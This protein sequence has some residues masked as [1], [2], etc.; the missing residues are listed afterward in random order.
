MEGIIKFLI[1]EDDQRILE[2]VSIAFNIRWPEANVVSTDLGEKGLEMVEAERPDIVILDL[3][4]PDISGFEVLKQIRLFSTVPIIVMSVMG[5]EEDVVRGLELGADEYVIKPFRQLEFLSRVK[6][7]LRI[8]TLPGEEQPLVYGPLRFETFMSKLFNKEKEV[9]LTRTEAL[10]LYQLMKAGGKV[11]TYS[12]LANIV[13][14]DDCPS[15]TESLRVYIRRLR[16]KLEADS[17]NPE[18]IHTKIG[19]GYY[20]EK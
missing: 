4:L 17:H 15:A 8:H 9:N 1:I 12:R 20:L 14:G 19:V 2:V 6:A 16:E 5:E 7:V 11:I 3:G 13:W 18:L 10:I